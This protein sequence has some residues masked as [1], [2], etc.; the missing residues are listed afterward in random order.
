MKKVAVVA[1][2][3]NEEENVGSFLALLMEQEKVLLGWNLLVVIA[4]GHS[5][6]GT[7]KVVANLSREFKNIHFL[8]VGQRGLGLAIVKGLDFAVDEL[9]ADALV[10]MEADLSNDPGQ[11]PQFLSKLGRADVVIGSRYSAR[12]RIVNW[13]WWRRAVSQAANVVLKIF[14]GTKRVSEFTNLYRAFR[15]EVWEELRPK[16]RLYRDWIFVP[17]FT[18]EVLDTGFRVRE[19]PIVYH[20]RFG[21]RSKMR[22][23]SYTKNLL[24][25]AL[26]Y[27]R[28][29]HGK[30]S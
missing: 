18:F 7:A 13:S 23:L 20:D 24:R 10:T 22:T 8:D 17:A 19:E 5:S 15:K 30:S 1:P 29:N 4:D 21:G 3:F 26:R 16:L 25:Y 27:R 2:T 28:R 6:D 9:L 14:A 11:L 12:G